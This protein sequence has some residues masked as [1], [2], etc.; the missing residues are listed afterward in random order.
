MRVHSDKLYNYIIN[1]VAKE[2]GYLARSSNHIR[3]PGILTKDIITDLQE[4]DI[5]IADLSYQNPNVYYE[6]AIRHY[7]IRKP[8]IHLKLRGETVPFDLKD[9]RY[10]S[11]SM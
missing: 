2:M 4:A 5:V 9:F 7:Y 8:Y 11:Y 10:I 6:L 1:P 3:G